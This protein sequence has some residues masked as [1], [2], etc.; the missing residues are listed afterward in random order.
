MLEILYDMAVEFAK[1]LFDSSPVF[2][3]ESSIYINKKTNKPYI[4]C[5]YGFRDE[6]IFLFLQDDIALKEVELGAFRYYE[7]IGE[8]N[9]QNSK[10]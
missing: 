5:G 6:G 8:L 7:Y 10:N 3:K 4:Y 1:A 9:E 2:I